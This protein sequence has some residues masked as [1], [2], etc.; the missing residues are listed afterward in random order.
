MI[1]IRILRW[2]DY[3]VLSRWSLNVHKGPCMREPRKSKE[4]VGEV[5]TEV[6]VWSD[7]RKEP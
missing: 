3:L 5:I 4:E 6:R 7:G 1:R 2:R